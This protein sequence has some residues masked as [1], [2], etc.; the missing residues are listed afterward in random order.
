MTTVEGFDLVLKNVLTSFTLF[1]K[2]Y[3]KKNHTMNK[4][5]QIIS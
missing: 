5:T 4:M 1:S 2:S 3:L